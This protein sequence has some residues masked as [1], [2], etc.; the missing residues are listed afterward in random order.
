[1]CWSVCFERMNR[2]FHSPIVFGGG[3]VDL[4]TTPEAADDATMSRCELVWTDGISIACNKP[5][6]L[7]FRECGDLVTTKRYS[8]QRHR[9]ANFGVNFHFVTVS[10]ST[11]VE[12]HQ[13]IAHISVSVQQ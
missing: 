13:G 2:A 6:R 3:I 4:W 5:N 11:L 12:F 1:M 9:F 10:R 8:S 7:L